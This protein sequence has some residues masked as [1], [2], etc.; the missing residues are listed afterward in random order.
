MTSLEA[1]AMWIEANVSFKQAR[2]IL[3]HLHIKFGYNV[4]VPFNKILSLGDITRQLLPTFD[5]FIYKKTDEDNDKV[6]EKIK[7]WSYNVTDLLELDFA[8]YLQ[9]LPNDKEHPVFGYKSRSFGDGLGVYVIIGSDHGGGKS[10]YLIRLNYESSACRRKHA[11]VDFGTRTLQIA[12]VDCKRDVLAVQKKLAPMINRANDKLQKSKLVAI[13]VNDKIVCKF[14]PV[15]CKDLR[16]EYISEKDKLVLKYTCN[17]KHFTDQLPINAKETTSIWTCIPNFKVLISGD[18]CFYATSS[19]RDGRSHCRCT[20]CDSSPNCWTD[21][22]RSHSVLTHECLSRFGKL[23]EDSSHLKNKPDTK[24]IVMPPL[25]SIEPIDYVIPLLH[26]EIGLVNKGWT[27]FGH[28]LDEFVENV[29]VNEARLK[30]E[31]VELEND[32]TY[33]NDEIDIN[34]V[35]KNIA[36]EVIGRR[37][38]EEDVNIAKESYKN[39]TLLLKQVSGLKKKKLA[40]LRL[41][42]GEIENER[43]ARKGDEG[44]VE[45]LLLGILESFNIKKQHFHGGAMN[46]VCCRRLLD[47]VDEVFERIVSMVQQKMNSKKH[48][49]TTVPIEELTR[50]ITRFNSLFDCMDVVFSKLRILDPTE[51]EIEEIDISI[52][53]LAEIWKELDLSVTPK[54]HILIC[55]TL[56]Q[57]IMFGGIAD[58]VEDFI[59][60]AHQIGKKLDHLVAR[61]NSQSFYQQEL[62]KIRRQ[63]LASDPLVTHR[64]SAVRQQAKRKFRP[65]SPGKKPTKAYNRKRVKREKRNNTMEKLLMSK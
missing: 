47:N 33:L 31:K 13:R 43:K 22:N 30:D 58:K 44:S 55:H 11:K 59:E 15:I 2:I 36:L 25:L 8:R 4:Q 28:F 60:K 56:D 39:S 14:V 34:T 62:V 42:K 12:E 38:D 24:G 3:R 18:L 65:D 35:N 32:I 9:S 49:E 29:S 20:Y 48:T 5:E 23:Y 16:T 64:L 53:G 50:V 21:G 41:V 54:M 1:A 57:V 10:R 52:K 7:Y 46:G 63:W 19:G 37:N 40:K 45:D 17:S 51:G 27:T 26:L 6:G 61:M